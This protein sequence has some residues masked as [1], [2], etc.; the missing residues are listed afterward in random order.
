MER[1]SV[2]AYLDNFLRGDSQP[3]YVQ[4]SGYRTVRSS[5]RDTADAAFRFARELAALG[6]RK[7]DRVFLWAPNSMEW[8]AIFLG[9]ALSGAIVIPMDDAASPEFSERVSQ[10]S[11][12]KLLVCSR[13]H[14]R[15]SFAHSAIP[16]LAVEELSESLLRHSPAPH[17]PATI[18]SNDVLEIVFTSGTTADPKGVVITHSNVLGNVAP[19]ELEISK[20]LKFERFVHPLR[21][22]NLLPLSHVFGQLLGVFLPQLMGGTV[23]FQQDWKPGAV[24]RAIH[25]ERVSVLVAVPHILQSLKE[26]IERDMMPANSAGQGFTEGGTNPIQLSAFSTS[27]RSAEGKHFLR[28]WWI[29]RKVHRQFGWKFW[30]LISGGATLDRDTEEFWGR[31]G[32]AVI[33]GYGMTETTSLVSLNH[34]FRL[35]KGSIGK[36]LPGREVKLAPDGEILVRGTGIAAGY[37]TESGFPAILEKEGWYHTGDIGELDPS[38]NLYFKG[39]KKDVIVTRAGMNVYPEDLEAA[40]RLQPE[41]KDCV[42]VTLER[43]AEAE[44]CAVLILQNPKVDPGSIVKRAN[45]SLAEYQRIHKWF[46]W[47]EPDFPRTSTQKPRKEAILHVL[48]DKISAGER[49]HSGVS[50]LS[51]IPLAQLISSI[52]GSSHTDLSSNANLESDLNLSSLDRVQLLAT[53]EDRY[54]VELNETRFAELNTV[55]DV[56]KLVRDPATASAKYHY[57]AW[58]QC[59]LVSLIRIAFHYLVLRPAVFLLGR[60]CIEG[61]ENLRKEEGPVL[62]ICNHTA[63][64]DPAFVLTALPGRLRHNLAIATAGEA[65][66]ALRVPPRSRGLLGKIYD[67]VKWTLG[68]SLLNLFPLPQEAG[69]RESFTY[70][71]ES[72]DRGHSLLV[73]P[74]G[75]H[76]KDGNLIPFRAGI[77]LLVSNLDIPVV[78]MRIDGLFEI[79]SAGRHFAHPG[80]I[81]IKIGRPVRF[82]SSDAPEEISRQLENQIGNL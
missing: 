14:L 13:Q 18:E 63:D 48:R 2:A 57:P 72:V 34:P 42:V 44:P 82:K 6:I 61:R 47:T 28:R 35:G 38:G 1:G 23:I 31:L 36:V 10:L 55:G 54:H 20:Y 32:Y 21:F 69:F 49:T 33:Q 9:S 17:S 45:E 81:K 37:W 8:V 41:V 24:I 19:L 64:V 29:F 39:R 79:K 56:A 27:L 78:P 46:V 62:V 77:G 71:G 30:A 52:T 11:D 12:A 58:A 22:L 43:N 65:L 76:T 3:A 51:T 7:G 4:P 74:E 59:W 66:E 75:H 16:K 53:L 60:R 80:E 15:T 73:F 5:Y 70:A 50:P 26:K 68:V 40:L 25:R 67:R